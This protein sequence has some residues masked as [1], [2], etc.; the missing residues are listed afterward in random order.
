MK[1]EKVY[2]SANAV[3]QLAANGFVAHSYSHGAHLQIVTPTGRVDFWPTTGKWFDG[4]RVK[5]RGDGMDALLRHLKN[6]PNLP[7]LSHFKGVPR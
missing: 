6:P 2:K 3:E 5:T 7:N 1:L 4:R